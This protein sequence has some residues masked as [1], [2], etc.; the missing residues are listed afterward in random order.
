LTCL[1][2]ALSWQV[3]DSYFLVSKEQELLDLEERRAAAR[4]ANEEV[5]II[6]FSWPLLIE[7]RSFFSYNFF[8]NNNNDNISILF[9]MYEN[10]HSGGCACGAR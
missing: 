9:E 1:N 7:N 6:P 5:A 10:L 3:S 4:K 8:E 2:P